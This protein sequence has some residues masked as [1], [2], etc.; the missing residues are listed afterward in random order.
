MTLFCLFVSIFEEQ[1]DLWTINSTGCQ[2]PQYPFYHDKCACCVEKGA[3]SCGAALP[4]RCSQCGLEQTC[5][6]MCNMTIDYRTIEKLSGL[7]YGSVTAPLA[8]AGPTYCW[9]RFQ[10]SNK[11]RIEIQ[12]YKVTGV[13]NFNGKKCVGGFL[14][15]EDGWD[16][17]YPSISADE[18]ISGQICA[19]N[20]RFFPP[21]V[22]F[23]DEMRATLKF[24]TETNEK[25][26]QFLA[27]FNF[28]SKDENTVGIR[29]KGGDY[30]QFTGMHDYFY[31]A[32]VVTQRYDDAISSFSSEVKKKLIATISFTVF[33]TSLDNDDMASPKR[34]CDWVFHD[35]TCMTHQSC[36]MTSPGYPGIYPS[37]RRCKYLITTSAPF[38]RIK[39]GFLSISLPEQLCDTNYIK[40][41][42]G[43][44]SSSPV[45]RTI[46]GKRWTQ[47]PMVKSTGPNLMM[48]FVTSN[49][50]P[51]F[52]FN[53]FYSYI[54]FSNA[55]VEEFARLV[56][57]S[58]LNDQKG[59]NNH[60]TDPDKKIDSHCDWIY[61]GSKARYGYIDASKFIWYA[62]NTS[63][64][65]N[66]LGNPHDVVEVMLLNYKLRG[67]YCDQFID[68]LDKSTKGNG[69]FKRLKR[70]C[71][72][73]VK[74]SRT[75][76]GAFAPRETFMSSGN[77]LN[78]K[79][80]LAGQPKSNALQAVYKFHNKLS[81]GYRIDRTVCDV[82]FYGSSEKTSGQLSSSHIEE[83]LYWNID[84]PLRCKKY[85]VPLKNQ[86]VTITINAYSQ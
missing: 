58:L 84:G 9:Y 78:I 56:D 16:I 15:F 77:Q 57:R 35:H 72:P 76:S 21:V 46:C 12:I 11:H 86:T 70:I 33:F 73:I 10:G 18:D 24:V 41:Y 17:S 4:S 38:T 59:I 8:V 63:C 81:D 19:Q 60:Q 5:G 31:S 47:L 34:Y 42:D 28:P 53:G 30:I 48:E 69:T 7:K 6:N 49:L 61:K 37:N 1:L 20:E 3:C 52:H 67:G 71:G 65:I 80:H 45:L 44:T 51:P 29:Q 32:D 55:V 36:L 50:V 68:I 82:I 75:Y 14:Q 26:T 25:N 22:I 79:L 39:V 85:F 27:F 54:E 23:R 62:A 74:W 40:F 83:L 66:F 43:R 13:G 2:C 64:S